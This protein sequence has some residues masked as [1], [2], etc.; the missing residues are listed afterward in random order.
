MPHKQPD[1]V[2]M[3][4]DDLEKLNRLRQSGAIT[5]EEF[6]IEKQ[7]L[8]NQPAGGQMSIADERLYCMLMHLS[9]LLGIL[10]PLIMWLIK[11]DSSKFIDQSGKIILNW[12]ISAII[13]GMG[14]VLFSFI[15]VGIP[16]L[17]ALGICYIV[18][19]IMGAVK[20]NEGILWKYPLSIEFFKVNIEE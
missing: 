1:N 20:A 15:V 4:Y 6:Q 13:Y 3:N 9:L 19:A 18:F 11:K 14:G 5:E 17:V 8:L 7:K 16:L 2:N 10:W 12:C